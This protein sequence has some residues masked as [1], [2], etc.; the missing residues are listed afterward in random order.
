MVNNV[1]VMIRI[2]GK[3]SFGT[4][5]DSVPRISGLL[6]GDGVVASFIA[7]SI[8]VRF[9]LPLSEIEFSLS[10]S[11]KTIDGLGVVFEV[12]VAVGLGVEVGFGDGVGV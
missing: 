10:E 8:S 6:V 5:D 9:S 7:K 4:L 11:A 12:G 2:T 3:P 1:P